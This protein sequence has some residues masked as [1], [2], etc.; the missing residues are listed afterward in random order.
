LNHLP[1][2]INRGSHAVRAELF[3]MIHARRD[4]RPFIRNVSAEAEIL[5]VDELILPTVV[6]HGE[7]DN[8]WICSP[9]ATW[10][11]SVS[12][13]L[14]QRLNP[15]LQRCTASAFAMFGR[16][17]DRACIDRVVMLNNWLLDSS[18]YP[19]VRRTALARTIEAA[20]QRWPQ[21]ALW[22]GSLNRERNAGLIAALQAAGCALIP[23]REVWL[24]DGIGLKL[25]MGSTLQRDLK[26]L[27]RTP[28]WPVGR[29]DIYPA[30]FSRIATLHGAMN[31]A[32]G[33]WLNPHYTAHFMQYWHQTGLLD[34]R[35]FR[36]DEGS[37]QAVVGIFRLGDCIS[38]PI[39]GFNPS[40]P[41]APGLYRLLMAR[42]LE[43]A[44][45]TN[46]TLSLGPG[47]TEFKR[48]R[49]G[50][51]LIEYSAVL[52]RHLP[53][54]ARRAVALLESVGSRFGAPV[55]RRLGR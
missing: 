45:L 29:G 44:M 1:A 52:A 10:C 4:T 42:L 5:R 11:D 19:P 32:A 30:D 35:G 48:Q 3:G 36:D 34:F 53:P 51:P 55:L 13:Q 37:L 9:R 33:G 22:F 31:G 50:R 49:G 47:Q 8:A 46:A 41:R 18:F 20:L 14:C 7:P 15:V 43:E 38:A 16:M 2:L 25:R 40:S 12:E 28:L 23:T 24:F 17:L 27:H 6:N 39:L 26:F 54:Q 21:H